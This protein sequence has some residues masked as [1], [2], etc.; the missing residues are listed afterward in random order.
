MPARLQSSANVPPVPLPCS[1]SCHSTLH[2]PDLGEKG[3]EILPSISTGHAGNCLTLPGLRKGWISPVTPHNRGLEAWWPIKSVPGE[4]SSISSCS[5]L[6]DPVTAE[7]MVLGV[8]CLGLTLLGVLQSRAQDSTQNLIP[9]P[10]LLKVPLQPGFQ[11][12]KVGTWK[13]S[14]RREQGETGSGWEEKPKTSRTTLGRM[15]KTLGDQ[16]RGSLTIT[17]PP[18]GSHT[19]FFSDSQSGRTSPVYTSSSVISIV[20]VR[21]AISLVSFARGGSRSPTAP[22][23][24]PP[25]PPTQ[26]NST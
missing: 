23:R 17:P 11:K 25:H 9:A 16:D 13:D 19:S 26:A 4:F 5:Y 2:N 1:P 21:W 6:L 20:R 14:C 7:T 8:L 10:S 22:C 3:T 15:D 18:S 12:D 24:G